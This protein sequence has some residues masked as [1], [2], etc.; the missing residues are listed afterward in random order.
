MESVITKLTEC[1]RVLLSR[2]EEET[3]APH[4]VVA[5]FHDGAIKAELR[6]FLHSNEH[7]FTS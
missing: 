6:D 7:V 5:E 2:K 4:H 1:V 3:Q